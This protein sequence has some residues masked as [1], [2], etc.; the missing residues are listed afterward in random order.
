MSMIMRK[1][2]SIAFLTAGLIFLAT[3]FYGQIFVSRRPI[4]EPSPHVRSG[5]KALLDRRF[6]PDPL[7]TYPL[8]G[9]RIDQNLKQRF[10]NDV[11]LAS[12]SKNMGDPAV[13]VHS[14]RLRA[15]GMETLAPPERNYFDDV[16]ELLTDDRVFRRFGSGLPVLT[17][18]VY[19]AGYRTRSRSSLSVAGS[20]GAIAEG[21]MTHVD[22]ML[23]VLGELGVGLDYPLVTSTDRVVTLADVL[24][25]S[26]QRFDFGRELDFTLVGY[27]CYLRQRDWTTIHGKTYSVDGIAEALVRR[28]P[29]S[30]ACNG[31]HRLYA[32]AKYCMWARRFPKLAAPHIREHC[33]NHLKDISR[34]LVGCQN[35]DGSWDGNWWVG[36]STTAKQESTD[37]I[38]HYNDTIRVTG[39]MLEWFAIVPPDL[40]P[41][42]D[43]IAR[44]AN[45]LLRQ[46][47]I[48]RNDLYNANLLPV[49]H[50]IRALL[51]LSEPMARV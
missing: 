38:G 32:I 33:E 45:Y 7:R 42:R 25:D 17:E 1:Y 12:V 44:A 29:A 50:A 8:E 10:L 19:G 30:G 34:H 6:K 39:H 9:L 15:H 31:T 35:E 41:P 24:E 14:L 43:V 47:E 46:F 36:T 21:G 51:N 2:L 37:L 27:C 28:S 48:N 3:H 22:I 23:C 13:A 18:T 11:V 5:S 49:T 40:R 20:I 4:S 16:L 26:M